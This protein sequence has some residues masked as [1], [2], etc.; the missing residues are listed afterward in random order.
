MDKK[1]FE[2]EYMSDQ[3]KKDAEKLM[4]KLLER[5]TDLDDEKIL[6]LKDRVMKSVM[7]D[8][9]KFYIKKKD[10]RRERYDADKIVTAISKSAER[11]DE[12]LSDCD[13]GKIISSHLAPTE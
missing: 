3:D 13:V 11:T 2:N 12:P 5:E 8:S 4:A 1:Y 6:I 9:L 10:G 7:D